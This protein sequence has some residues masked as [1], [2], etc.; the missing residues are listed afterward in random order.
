MGF[1]LFKFEAFNVLLKRLFEKIA[2]VMTIYNTPSLSACCDSSGNSIS[3]M[4][5]WTQNWWF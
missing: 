2:F 5:S 1:F 3:A 4:Y